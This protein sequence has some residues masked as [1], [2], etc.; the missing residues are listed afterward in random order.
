MTTLWHDLR[1]ACR[2]LTNQPGFSL[3]IVGIL[4]IGVAGMT[5]VFSLFNGLFLRPF[6]VPTEKRL[7]ELHETDPQSGTPQNVGIAYPRFEAW[8]QYN[9]T[10]ECMGFCSFWSATISLDDKAERIGI[11]LATHDFLRVLGLRPVLGRY[12]AAEEDRPGGPSVALVNHGLWERLFAKDPA[13]LGRTVRLDGEPL[14]IIGV[15]PPEADF[16]ER[17]EI[18]RPLCADAQGHHGGM[19]TFAIGLRKEGVTVEQARADLI[20]IHQGWVRQNSDQ[21]VMTLPVAIPFRALY[22]EQVKQYES[23]IS[24]LLGVVGFA[25]LTA[26]CNVMSIMLARGAVATKEYALRAALGASR[27]QLIRHV[28]VESLVLSVIGGF[29]GVLLGK[30]ALTLVLSRAASLIPSWMKF[31]LDVRCALFCA[32]VIGA[33][34]LLSGLLPALHAALARNLHAVL[35]SAGTRATVSRGRRRTLNVI[36]TAE[37]AL[38]LTLLVG[39]GLLLR[40]F[41][42]VQSVNPG[43][44]Q[45]GVLTYN[46]FLP[47]GP[48]YDEGKRRAFWEQHLEKIRALPGVTQAA[49]SN[50]VP[51]AWP[52][53]GEF[54]VEGFTPT[55]PG[56]SRPSALWQSVTP[57]YFETLGL[58]LLAGRFLTDDDDRKDS[59]KVAVISEAFVRRFWPGQNPLDKRFRP[60]KSSDWIRVVGVVGDVVTAGLDQPPWLIVY[61]PAGI[62][63]PFGMFGIVRTAD[64]GSHRRNRAGG[65]PDPLS[66]MTSVRQIVRAADAGLPIQDIGTM[67]QRIDASLWLRRLSAWVFG[68]PAAAAALMACA[69]IYG[70]I[71][72]SVSR[73]VQEIGIRMTLGA[74][75]RE[76]IRMVTGQALRLIIAGLA[77]GLAGGFILSRLFASLPG[78]LYQVSPN[79]PVTFLGVG[80]LLVGVAL[81]AC[82]I[83]ARRAARTDPMTALRYE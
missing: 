8:R 12:F 44:R 72:Y 40:T 61:E 35:Q 42:Q 80:V 43:F 5:T 23:G 10:F 20:R 77:L 33:G 36:V 63:V 83:P 38:A 31:P 4:A 70:V 52:S 28:L 47:I 75:R 19:G 24:L 82:Y 39:A 41:R 65:D 60:A 78:M 37:I 15:L 29:V 73:R 2:R 32:A 58:R 48:Y 45:A 54:E 16:P 49:L 62:D 81:L 14:T 79:D 34:A 13:V 50:Y 53:F 46:I 26:C 9:Q 71:N 56:S 22:R 68:L 59:E 30:W 64:E 27:G 57:G 55:G 3:M 66:L 11:R 74:S 21:N 1:L 17:R 51:A 7:M 76:V 69:G 18:W 25:M 67:A 6:P